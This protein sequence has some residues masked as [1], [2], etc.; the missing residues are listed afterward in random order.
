MR[1]KYLHHS[2]MVHFQFYSKTIVEEEEV[3]STEG[4]SVDG[5]Q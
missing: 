3:R 5:D 1:L 2:S 4:M